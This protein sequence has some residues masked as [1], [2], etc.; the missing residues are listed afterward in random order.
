MKD[1]KTAPTGG[2]DGIK[3]IQEIL[4]PSVEKSKVDLENMIKQ[5]HKLV[6]DVNTDLQKSMVELKNKKDTLHKLDENIKKLKDEQK[7]K[8]QAVVYA[9]QQIKQKENDLEKAQEALSIAMIK[10][11]EAEND[12]TSMQIAGGVLAAFGLGII[13]AVLLI[14]DATALKDNVDSCRKVVKTAN[15]ER[16]SS[17]VALAKAQHDKSTIDGEIYE[18]LQKKSLKEECFK[19]KGVAVDNLKDYQKLVI[20][21][22]EKVK[23]VDRELTTFYGRFKVLHSEMD[24]GYSLE[25]LN[26]NTTTVLHAL[27]AILQSQS[28]RST[29]DQLQLKEMKTRLLEIENLK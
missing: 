28:V 7:G 3:F 13:G 22:D 18:L 25:C 27:L 21:L 12:R 9:E 24:G 10:L 15:D 26:T 23:N 17:Q 6:Q 8:A 16:L 11:H 4:F 5:A 14:V 19:E 29:C 2:L 1:L 20:E